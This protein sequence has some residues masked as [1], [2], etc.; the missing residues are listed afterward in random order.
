MIKVVERCIHKIDLAHP[1]WYHLHLTPLLWLYIYD[2][3]APFPTKPTPVS[4]V[5][6]PFPLVTPLPH[7][8]RH[9]SLQT[10]L[11]T[12][13]NEG[14]LPLGEDLPSA[15]SIASFCRR[16]GINNS[17]PS[18]DAVP[19]PESSPTLSSSRRALIQATDITGVSCF[20]ELEGELSAITYR[21]PPTSPVIDM[22]AY[23]LLSPV[24]PSLPPA[25]FST[26]DPTTA[27]VTSPPITSSIDNLP[28]CIYFCTFDKHVYNS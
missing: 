10:L 22:S 7:L 21:S 26:A 2:P 8:L 23:D 4:T 13:R 16:R 6:E 15:A 9:R 5:E 14:S 11:T 28:V 1:I 12:M 18:P 17:P 20:P 24:I 3:T 27:D 19:T 25:D